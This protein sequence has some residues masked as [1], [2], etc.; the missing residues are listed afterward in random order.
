M[1]DAQGKVKALPKAVSGVDI[2]HLKTHKINANLHRYR[3]QK[4][5]TTVKESVE[6]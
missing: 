1:R 3:N 5:N 4:H 2:F 6:F